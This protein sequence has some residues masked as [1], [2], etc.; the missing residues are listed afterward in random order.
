MK[1]V[2]SRNVSE[3]LKY[4]LQK[5]YECALTMYFPALDKTSKKR[6][7]RG[8]V[9]QRI[10]KFLNDQYDIINFVTWG[11]NL[12]PNNFKINGVS[13]SD[14]V[15]KYARCSL[16]HEGQ[17]DERLEIIGTY[18]PNSLST[19]PGGFSGE[20]P[21]ILAGQGVKYVIPK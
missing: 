19:T 21:L 5:E 17:L 12:V 10:K 6:L 7:P 1:K 3:G 2:V 14:I 8:N 18:I 15:Y 16:I 9:G 13:F 20:K 4:L 11:Y